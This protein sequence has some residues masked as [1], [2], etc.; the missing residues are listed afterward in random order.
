MKRDCQLNECPFA[1]ASSL[2]CRAAVLCAGGFAAGIPFENH[3]WITLIAPFLGFIL[4]KWRL[5]GR[6]CLQ[7]ALLLPSLFLCLG[8]FR[9][10]ACFVSAKADVGDLPPGV[11]WVRGSIAS[12]PTLDSNRFR[13][14]LTVTEAGLGPDDLHRC[15]GKIL[16]SMPLK[17]NNTSFAFGQR[18]EAHGMLLPIEPNSNPAGFNPQRYYSYRHITRI[19]QSK[20]PESWK[21]IANPSWIGW[22]PQLAL[23]A[24]KNLQNSLDKL[25]PPLESSFLAGIMLGS[26]TQIPNSFQDDFAVTGSSHIL[27]ASGMNVGMVAAWLYLLSRFIPLPKRY[28]HRALLFALFFYTLVCGG[29]PSIVRADLM[30]SLFLCAKLLDRDGDLPISVAL[31]AFLILLFEP[32]SLYD[33]GFQLSYAT[34]IPIIAL[35]PTFEMISKSLA[36]PATSRSNGMIRKGEMIL[37]E[38]ALLTVA[39]QLGSLP[40]TILYFNQFSIVALGVNLLVVPTLAYLTGM[41]FIV[42]AI[43]AIW[44]QLAS[45]LALFVLSPALLFLEGAVHAGASV[46]YASVFVS[47]PN[48]AWI[49]CFYIILAL[50]IRMLNIR[51]EERTQD[52]KKAR[53]SHSGNHADIAIGNSDPES[54]HSP[55]R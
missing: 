50:G 30:A 9:A 53:D 29:S 41:G 1:R 42:W 26:R 16:I 6:A 24:R 46:P 45:I 21:I 20:N 44:L 54:S 17:P 33:I 14:E 47:S 23:N 40:L 35:Q 8:A 49:F 34:V 5:Y 52:E 38:T 11:Y 55:P 19:M 3:P 27:A 31:S 43:S 2:C 12:E 10:H 32:G 51:C 15:S 48:G 25:L 7:Q 18:L 13:C 28:F 39:A 4:C 22:I 37:A 36:S